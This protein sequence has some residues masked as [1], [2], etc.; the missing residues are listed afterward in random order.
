MK[1]KAPFMG[2]RNPKGSLVI[3]VRIGTAHMVDGRTLGRFDVCLV[4]KKDGTHVQT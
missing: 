3:A 1:V 2:K 4:I